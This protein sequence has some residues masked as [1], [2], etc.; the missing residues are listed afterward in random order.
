MLVGLGF[1][2]QAQQAR[3]GLA[4]GVQ[5]E[6]FGLKRVV[7]LPGEPAFIFLDHYLGEKA[8]APARLLVLSFCA[9]WCAPCREELP[10]LVRINRRYAA[11]GLKILL[12]SIDD[13]DE[14]VANMAKLL[15]PD[16]ALTL[17]SDRY[18]I[19]IRRFFGDKTPLPSHAL[20]GPDSV[21]RELLTGEDR[22]LHNL[23]QRIAQFLAAPATEA[24][25]AAE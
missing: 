5:V 16:E 9:S 13:T 1:G 11:Q 12:V 3:P 4:P 17:I 8:K 25:P 24:A 19:V 10:D 18:Q 22:G 15:P 20:I 21:L 6:S 7:G 23:E 2:L 14:G